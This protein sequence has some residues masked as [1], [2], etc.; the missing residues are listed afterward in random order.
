M[1]R[2][3]NKLLVGLVKDPGT[4]ISRFEMPWPLLTWAHPEIYRAG[5]LEIFRCFI[6]FFMA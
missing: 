2:A 1:K 3:T 6:D 4:L 5:G